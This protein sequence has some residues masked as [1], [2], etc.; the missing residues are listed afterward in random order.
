MD[1]GTTTTPRAGEAALDLRGWL[2]LLTLCAAQFMV[3]LDFSI[4]TVALPAIGRDLGFTTTGQLQWVMTAFILPTAGLLLL[5]GRVSDL[6]GRRGLFLTG[7]VVVTVFSLVAGLATG[8]GMLIA[9]R[10]GQGI[11]SAMVG[12]TALALLT[13]SF[14]EGPARDRALGVSG[15]LLSL[16]FV[17]GTI[18]GGVIT[19]GLSWRWTMLVLAIG[20]AVVLVAGLLLVRRD[21]ERVRARLDVPGALC[22]TVG[23]LALVYGISTGSTA[24]WTALP[25]IGALVLA[26]VL[27]ASFVLVEARSPAPLVPLDVLARPTVHW[28]GLIGLVTFGMCGGV[29][30][31]V[32]LYLQDVLGWSPLTTG[33]AFLAEG[34]AAIAGGSLVP[35]MTARIGTPKTLITGLT[36]QTLSTAAMVLL[37]P[38]SNLALILITTAGL[39]FGHVVSVVAFIGIMSSGLSAGEH[40]LSGG[41]AQTSQQ[42]GSALGVAVLTAVV[43]LSSSANGAEVTLAGLRAGFVTAATVTLLGAMV[44]LLFLRAVGTPSSVNRLTRHD[45]PGAD[46]DSQVA[47]RSGARAYVHSQQ[48]WA[49][50]VGDGGHQSWHCAS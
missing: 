20:G 7:L 11:G 25:T 4:V 12:P 29:T 16:G 30:L 5:A 49:V 48:K 27:L 1:A 21:S 50:D 31:L 47:A 14:A 44:A 40:G 34:V 38:S 10:A 42:V 23:L 45:P 35:R 26:A 2:T 36:V 28:G 32:S 15:A 24:G 17:V 13:S 46:R 3:A 37:A 41:L 22:A 9:A 39:G 6:L 19:S 33:V 43:A 18:G 8:P